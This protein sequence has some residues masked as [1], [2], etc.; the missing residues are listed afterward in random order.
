LLGGP[1]I[2]VM[3]M[4]GLAPTGQ[5]DRG[6]GVAVSGMSTAAGEYPIGQRQIAVD[7]TAGRAQ[8]ARRIPTLSREELAAAP[9]LF[10][11][12]QPGEL[13]PTRIGNSAG[14]TMVARHPRYV[15]VFDDEPVVG[16]DQ[17]IGHPVQEMPAH[18][19]DVMVVPPE[20][21]GGV[22]T[23]TGSLS[24]LGTPVKAGP[25]SFS[26][27]LALFPLRV[28]GGGTQS[29]VEVERP[30]RSEDER[31]RGRRGSAAYLGGRGRGKGIVVQL[32][33]C[34]P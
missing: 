31:P 14:Q 17:L 11:A 19:G 18:V 24:V 29:G 5:V 2:E 3:L 34:L 30:Q 10:V 16:L 33:W 32:I 21:G 4:I 22:S 1:G 25:S 15:Q 27:C 13:G 7:V 20:S 12:Q 28:G 23:V 9:G 6:V 26:C 8:L